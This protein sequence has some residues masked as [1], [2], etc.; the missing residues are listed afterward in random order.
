[1]GIVDLIICMC[2]NMNNFIGGI[3]FNSTN[4]R[5]SGRKTSNS[6]KYVEIIS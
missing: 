5:E 2:V 6:T 4:V 3:K 1:M